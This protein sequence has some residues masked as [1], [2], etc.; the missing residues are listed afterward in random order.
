MNT[1]KDQFEI[2]QSYI[3]GRMTGEERAAFERELSDDEDVRK[4]YEQLSLLSRAVMKS[5]Q[6]ADL[7]ASFQEIEKQQSGTA[8]TTL[9]QVELNKVERE[10]NGMENAKRRLS[11][12]RLLTI[13]IAAAACVA[14]G[15]LISYNVR[16]AS[17]GFNYAPSQLELGDFRNSPDDL[18]DD[19]VRLYNEGNFKAALSSFE[20]AEINIDNIMSKLGDS[21]TDIITRERLTIE[22]HKIEWYRALTLMKA[23][24]VWAARSAVRAISESGSP[25][26]GEATY[27][28][29]KVY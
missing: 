23:K 1:E 4:H 12:V 5:N 18:F 16:L 20:E 6:E 14:A 15:I 2:I 29:Q 28:L 13:S 10:L 21:D 11:R 27:I 26:S 24:K 19:A 8:D 22:L 17:S 25:F 7:R 9:S 3:L